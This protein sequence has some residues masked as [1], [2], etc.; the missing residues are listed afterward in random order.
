M[1][2]HARKHRITAFKQQTL[3]FIG[4]K[5]AVL[6][7]VHARVL[8]LTLRFI[9]N[10]RGGNGHVQRLH[11]ADHGHNDVLI[12]ERQRFSGDAGFFLPHQNAGWFG[13]INLAEIHRIGRQIGGQHLHALIFQVTHG[14]RD[15]T[16]RL[17]FHPTVA[18]R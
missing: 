2:R 11:H 6:T 10:Q 17:H 12:G 13:V 7:F 3:L 9:Q 14:F 16:M 1:L 18:A 8:P 4:I 5:Q 15:M